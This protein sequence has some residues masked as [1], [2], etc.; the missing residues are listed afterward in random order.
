MSSSIRSFKIKAKKEDLRKHP[1]L[2]RYFDKLYV[3][4]NGAV[5]SSYSVAE[6]DKSMYSLAQQVYNEAKKLQVDVQKNWID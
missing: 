2:E 5:S 4:R 1:Q 6:F 3:H